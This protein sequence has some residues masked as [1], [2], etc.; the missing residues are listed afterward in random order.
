MP[1]AILNDARA[2]IKYVNE[3][4][5]YPMDRIILFGRSIGSGIAV[6]MAGE[7][8]IRG[9]VLISA[10]TSIRDV[11]KHK[12]TC[13]LTCCVSNMLRSKDKIDKVKCP[14]LLIH[15]KKDNLIPS[16]MSVE[17]SEQIKGEKKVK[18]HPEMDHNKFVPETDIY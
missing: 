17:L 5:K 10:Y 18:I 12:A 3:E 4:L 6:Q 13:L 1:N 11:I 15:G 7:F 8:N 14:V 2:V 9:L 16:R